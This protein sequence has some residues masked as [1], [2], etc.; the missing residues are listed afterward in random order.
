[1]RSHGGDVGRLPGAGGNTQKV[2]EALS[3]GAII[4]AKARRRNIAVV[5]RDISTGQEGEG[6][7]QKN[8]RPGQ[9]STP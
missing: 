5:G 1:M 6:P 9:A 7:G 2:K 8:P 4:S 3:C